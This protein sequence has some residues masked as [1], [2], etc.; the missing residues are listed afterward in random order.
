MAEFVLNVKDIEAFPKDY[1]FAVSSGWLVQALGSDGLRPD[2]NAGEATLSVQAQRSG[3]SIL[4]TG[5]VRAHLIGE[6][7]RCLEDAPF[8]VDAALSALLSPQG[9]EAN[10]AARELELTPEDLDRDYYTGEQLVLD[11]LVRDQLILNA[12]MQPLCSDNCK[13]IP[14]PS[15]VRPGA[16]FAQGSAMDGDSLDP[17]LAPLLKFRQKAK[18]SEE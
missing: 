16:D 11:D 13:G 15:H 18:P 5:Q 4:I 9:V 6:C 7:F 2:L 14:L 17:R 3:T 8:E 1:A 12:P 10:L